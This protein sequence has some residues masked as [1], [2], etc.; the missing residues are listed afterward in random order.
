MPKNN[1]G[2]ERI[3][4]KKGQGVRNVGGGT[5][6]GGQRQTKG[7]WKMKQGDGRGRSGPTNKRGRKTHHH[8]KQE[9]KKQRNRKEKE[10]HT[11]KK[12]RIKKA[13]ED[14]TQRYPTS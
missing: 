1:E 12:H 10:N 2:F 3:R 11:N 8:T 4:Q 6:E 5:E 14:E 7:P 13:R 9:R